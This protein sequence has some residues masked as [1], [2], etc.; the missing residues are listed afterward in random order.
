M[1]WPKVGPNDPLALRDFADFLK[2]CVEAMP[3]V[4]GLLVLNDSEENHKLLKK[5]PE[6]IVRKWSRIV[7][8]E[9][10]KSGDYP[11]FNCFAEFVQKEARIVCNPIAS[12]LLFSVKSDGRLSKGVKSFSTNTQ[13]EHL[14]YKTGL[15]TSKPK[16]PCLVCKED[17]HGIAK[18]PVFAS[19]SMEDK[20]S[21]IHLNRLCFGCLRKGH[22]TKECRTR[23]ICG[24]CGQRHPTCLHEKRE[25]QLG[26]HSYYHKR[27]NKSESS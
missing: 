16:L 6:W 11:S 26:D 27:R 7:V 22:I 14:N 19:K 10:D 24:R 25:R 5:M 4:R 1:R 20:G 2:G 18:C 17:H 15:L 3:H 23:H 12:P 9:L 13:A 8:E 21:F